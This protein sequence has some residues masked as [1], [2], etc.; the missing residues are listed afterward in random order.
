MSLNW[1]MSVKLLQRSVK[2]TTV[3][4]AFT[5]FILGERGFVLL[6][7]FFFAVMFLRPLFINP[8]CPLETVLCLSLFN[9]AALLL[10]ECLYQDR[11]VSH[12]VEHLELSHDAAFDRSLSFCHFSYGDCVVCTPRNKCSSK[13][14]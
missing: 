4:V 5:P 14:I 12:Y 6:N 11:I 1:E 2:K 9:L 13:Y 7:L 8:L 10:S 3:N